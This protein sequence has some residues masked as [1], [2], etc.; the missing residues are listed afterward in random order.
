MEFGDERLRRIE[1]GG[2]KMTRKELSDFRLRSMTELQVV[3]YDSRIQR[4]EGALQLW[5]KMEGALRL[6]A[7]M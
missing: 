2:P 6:K 7:G 4:T 5:T 1:L 3:T